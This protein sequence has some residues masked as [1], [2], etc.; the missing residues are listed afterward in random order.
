MLTDPRITVEEAGRGLSMLGEALRNTDEGRMFMARIQLSALFTL[1]D[2]AIRKLNNV[3]QQAKW[4]QK[5][6]G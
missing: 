1:S 2:E 3:Y 6:R 4:V 5:E